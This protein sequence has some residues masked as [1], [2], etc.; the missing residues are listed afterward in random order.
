M[1]SN[2]PKDELILQLRQ[3]NDK[4]RFILADSNLPCIY[5]ELSKSEMLKCRSGFPGCGRADDLM[6]MPD[7]IISK[8]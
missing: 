3:E 2:D 6:I 4:L 1:N 5:C 8:I 7:R